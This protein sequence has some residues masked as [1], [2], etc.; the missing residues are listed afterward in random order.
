MEIAQGA[1]G[2]EGSYDVKIEGKKIIISA[3]HVHAS[4]SVGLAI[5]EDLIY[6]LELLKGKLPAW[7][8]IVIV[9]GEAAVP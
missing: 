4:G 6:F 5:E 8:Q 2:P 1:V 7:A 3:K 9:A